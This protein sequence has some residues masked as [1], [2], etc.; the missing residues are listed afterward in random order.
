MGKAGIIMYSSYLLVHTGHSQECVN[1]LVSAESVRQLGRVAGDL[2]NDRKEQQ[3]IIPDITFTCSGTVTEWIVAAE[4][5]GGG[6]DVNFPEMQVWRETAT[7]SGVYTKIHETTMSF[8]EENTAG[9]YQYTITPIDVQSGD[10]L[11]MFEPDKSRLE[12]YY[13]DTYGPVN[14][15]TSTGKD[16]IVP[17]DGN[18]DI[19]AGGMTVKTQY[20]LP[21]LTV[22]IGKWDL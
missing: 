14:Y 8:S 5:K 7:G 1:G 6:M 9:I 21:L 17:P 18:F 13:T 15:Y 19:N 12:L 3:R 22:T 2:K 11:G 20:D 4:W 10:V 16:V